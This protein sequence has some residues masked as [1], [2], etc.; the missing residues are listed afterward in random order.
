MS[1]V[2]ILLGPPGTGKTHAL[3]DTVADAAANGISPESIGYISFTRG[4]ANVARERIRLRLPELARTRFRY[5]RTLH[6]LCF[7][8]I[9]ATRA[10][11]LGAE[12]MP[13]FINY[14]G[15][16][17]RKQV[18]WSNFGPEAAV[19][20][21][22]RGRWSS[23][24]TSD[25]EMLYLIGLARNQCRPLED[26]YNDSGLDEPLYVLLALQDKLLAYKR[27]RQIIDYTDLL[28]E[29]MARGEAPKLALLCIDE[30]QDLSTL[31]WKVA[32]R[33]IANA[34]KVYI[35]GDDDQAIYTWA[36]A[37]VK[38]FQ[39]C[40]GDYR[41]LGQSYRVPRSVHQIAERVSARMQSRLPKP[42][43]PR[44][45]DSGSV[46]FCDPYD[47]DYS[48]GQ[49]LILARTG[50]P[51]IG[52]SQHL[53]IMYGT[54]WRTQLNVRLSTIHGV[55]G[56]EADNVVL[57]TDLT[58]RVYDARN[59]DDEL[60][61]LYVALTRS[62]RNLFLSVPRTERSYDVTAS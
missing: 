52:L 15:L 49:W 10:G 24:R 19:M 9:G 50:N 57:I 48:Q 62:R 32:K 6:S 27:F 61:V 18:K 44:E 25:E 20:S 31:Q 3:I 36:G 38:R 23:K 45:G 29:F 2:E 21:G 13:D 7:H 33:L 1:H 47:L 28:E 4:A 40:Q 43:Q 39:Q 35:A 16:D 53:Q 8:Q 41:V 12:A 60:R 14:C 42:Y 51:L 59:T 30:G 56:D 22:S 55:K 34:E 11:M 58:Q 54:K 26:V 5:F 17:I 46:S 37:N